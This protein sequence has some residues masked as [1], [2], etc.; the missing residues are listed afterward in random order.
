[1]PQQWKKTI[2][3]ESGISVTAL[4]GIPDPEGQQEIRELAYKLW[5]ARGC[6]IGTPEEDWFRAEHELRNQTKAISSAA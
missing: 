2:T 4:E 6:P 1:M 3:R 5:L